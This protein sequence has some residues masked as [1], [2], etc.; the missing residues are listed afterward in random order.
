MTT[1]PTSEQIRELL[2]TPG[3]IV[4]PTLACPKCGHED[5][6]MNYCDGCGL[7]P[8]HAVTGMHADDRCNDGDLEHNHRYCRRCTYRWRTDDVIGA[9]RVC[10]R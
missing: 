10:P 4:V 3:P 7:R 2:T 9:R 8:Y 6:A 1:L 5:T